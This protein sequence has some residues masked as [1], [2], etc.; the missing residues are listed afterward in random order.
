MMS[1]L[2]KVSSAQITEGMYIYK[3]GGKWVDHPFW[4]L[5]F[6]VTDSKTLRTMRAL[7]DR[8]I[9][10]DTS[11][12]LDVES[13]PHEPSATSENA[14]VSAVVREPALPHTT[15]GLEVLQAEAVR[16][17]AK[18][19]VKTLFRD[20][21]M[22]KALNVAAASNIVEEL[23]DAIMRNSAAMLSVVR[24]K[25]KGDYTYLH[26]VAVAAL[27]MALGRCLGF[28]GGALTDLG[29]AGLLHDIGKVGI[30]DTILNKPGR[31]SPLE[32]TSV[33]L[34]PQTG[35]DILR[36]ISNSY[37]VALDVC[38]HHHEKVDGSGYPDKLAGDAISRAARMGAICD[39]YDAITSDRPYKKGW[40]PVEAIRRMAEWQD[41]HFDREIFHT[42]V[43]MIG[44]YPT[45]T[46]V[47]LQSDRLAVVL[48]Q[49][50]SSTLMPTVRAFR[51]LPSNQDIEPVVLDLEDQS[52][53][54]VGIEDPAGM[55]LDMPT[56]LRA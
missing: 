16:E 25:K 32:M 42:F 45:G 49:G 30:S 6:L 38:L 18:G 47:R 55:D 43:K 17:R 20:A 33:R 54:I 14:E 56:L 24:L 5:S 10:I 44:I 39:V 35:W 15:F 50:Q 2:K 3:I 52:D 11:K 26:S 12:G 22:G 37:P 21:R 34:H 9:W 19:V 1:P 31:L 36:G 8:E 46:L 4:K 13:T 51:S 48:T 40:Q 29:I 41:G 7:G 23:S 28:D 53:S 27:M